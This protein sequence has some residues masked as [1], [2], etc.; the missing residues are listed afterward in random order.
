MPDIYTVRINVRNMTMIMFRIM[1]VYSLILLLL[2]VVLPWKFVLNITSTITNII[3]IIIIVD[4][5]PRAIIMCNIV[6]V[7]IVLLL[8]NMTIIMVPIRIAVVV[9]MNIRITN[10]VDRNQHIIM[11]GV[12]I[13]NGS[14]P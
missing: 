3:Y 5:F 4:M 12:V 8:P 9:S 11:I 1:V 13:I 7:I 14:S 2:L 10:M 6:R